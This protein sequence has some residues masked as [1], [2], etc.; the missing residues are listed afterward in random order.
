MTE[1]EIPPPQ[2]STGSAFMKIVRVG[3]D[4]SKIS[5]AVALERHGDL[6][7]RCRIAMGAVAPVPM[8][9]NDSEE[10]LLDKKVDPSLIEEIGQKVAEEI[11]PI[12]D[13]RSNAGYRRQVAASLFEDVFWKAWDRAKGEEEE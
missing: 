10:I 4:I 7:A 13:V 12:T 8:R 11:E 1:I 3:V 9:M 2:D 5:C 6:C